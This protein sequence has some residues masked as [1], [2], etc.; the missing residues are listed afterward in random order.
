MNIQRRGKS[1]TTG[2][3]VALPDGDTWTQSQKMRGYQSLHLGTLKS[4]PNYEVSI[5]CRIL[6]A[7]KL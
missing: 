3:K 2:K 7:S 1:R 4:E 6:S 5:V